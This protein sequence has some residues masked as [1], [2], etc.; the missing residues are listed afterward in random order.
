MS[1]EEKITRN[2]SFKRDKARAQSRKQTAEVPQG[3]AADSSPSLPPS[4][5]QREDIASSCPLS[6]HGQGQRE[7]PRLRPLPDRLDVYGLGLLQAPT[8]GGRGFQGRRVVAVARPLVV[9][10]AAPQEQRRVGLCGGDALHRGVH[11]VH[12]LLQVHVVVCGG[13]RGEKGGRQV[14][15]AAYISVSLLLDCKRFY[16]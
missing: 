2:Q 5:S 12:Q 1:A 6:K 15:S 3:G 9:G 8:A 14:S 10:V 7:D 13:G 11:V 4:L 16:F